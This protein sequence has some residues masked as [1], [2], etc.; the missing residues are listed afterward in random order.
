M[1]RA[2]VLAV[3]SFLAIG[4]GQD[5]GMYKVH[6]KPLKL[7]M[8]LPETVTVS[9]LNEKI[10]LNFN[11]EGRQIRQCWLG[12]TETTSSSDFTNV[13]EF[14]NKTS[15]YY[16]TEI[17]AGGSGG[18]EQILTGLLL[19]PG[20]NYAIESHDQAEYPVKPD[21]KFCLQY[22]SSLEYLDKKEDNDN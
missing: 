21:A 5:V 2:F 7:M 9:F 14:S 10:H 11:A 17:L 22:L 20:A 13:I 15:L 8:T 1:K 19:T 6:L 16:T 18:E 4:I 12:A 3:M